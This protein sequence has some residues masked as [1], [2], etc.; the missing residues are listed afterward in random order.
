MGITVKARDRS[1]AN[2][3][4]SCRPHDKHCYSLKLATVGQASEHVF[5]IQTFFQSS[6]HLRINLQMRIWTRGTVVTSDLNYFAILIHYQTKA[7]NAADCYTLIMTNQTI[8]IRKM[9]RAELDTAVDWAR[10]EGWNPGLHDAEAFWQ[11]DPDGFIA[12]EA[13]GEIIG[14][15]SIV[16]YDGKFGFMGFFIVRPD[17]RAQGLGRKLWIERRNRLLARLDSVAAIGMD[18]VFNMQPFYAKGGFQFSHRDIKMQFTGQKLDFDQSCIAQ[19]NKSDFAEI[20]KIDK[21]CFGF[22]RTGFLENWLFMK[23]SV[24][25]CYRKGSD[26]LGF[27]TIRRCHSG[28]KI[29]PLF[30]SNPEVADQLFRALNTVATDDQII[31]CVPEKN[32]AALDMAAQY[33]MS[34]FPGCAKMYYGKFPDLPY[35]EIYG[36]TSFELG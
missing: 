6:L 36:V 33:K 21:C 19:I 25:Y 15:G 13:D 27:G 16:S 30:A 4:S 26:Y 12:L 3:F 10:Q 8:S 11:T 28:W 7:S 1:K 17:M 20:A 29:G 14:T 2:F 22:D 18:G 35:N 5:H 9:T 23:D 31:L 24:S 32:Q 34:E